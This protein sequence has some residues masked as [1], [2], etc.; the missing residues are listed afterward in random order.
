MPQEKADNI[1][2]IHNNVLRSDLKCQGNQ[3]IMYTEI[4]HQVCL[5]LIS[6]TI[7][8]LKIYL[9]KKKIKL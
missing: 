4:D 7:Y 2:Q 9:N 3:I 5:P 8:K 1:Q 6:C